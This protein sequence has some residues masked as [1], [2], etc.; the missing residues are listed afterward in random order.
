MEILNVLKDDVVSNKLAYSSLIFLIIIAI[1]YNSYRQRDS[2]IGYKQIPAANA[3]CVQKS[4]RTTYYLRLELPEKLNLTFNGVFDFND[5][6]YLKSEISN[7]ET[8]AKYLKGNGLI[9]QL[10]IGNLVIF[11]KGSSFAGLIFLAFFIWTLLRYFCSVCSNI[12]KS[13]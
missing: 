4:G 2:N 5:C 13:I 9:T 11:E 8:T 3:T 6:E 1:V 10:S 7:N 12:R